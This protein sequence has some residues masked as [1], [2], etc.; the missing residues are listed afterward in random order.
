[1][2]KSVILKA[3]ESFSLASDKPSLTVGLLPRFDDEL[4]V[5]DLIVRLL[6]LST[7]GVE[8]PDALQLSPPAR[9]IPILDG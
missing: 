6:A 9:T 8:V 3:T 1:V 7:D 4:P 2:V 5:P